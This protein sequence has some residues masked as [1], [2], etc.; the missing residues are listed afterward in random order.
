MATYFEKLKDPR[1][2]KKRLEVFERDNFKCTNCGSSEKT[3]HVHHG[4]YTSDTEPWEYNIKSLHTVCWEC[5]Q[6][7]EEIKH[8]VHVTI[9]R[10]S[11]KEMR[12]LFSYLVKDL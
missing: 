12:K 6:E 8:D 5:P 3:L 11:I 4:Y 1:W 2:Q 7:F 10:Y 9:A